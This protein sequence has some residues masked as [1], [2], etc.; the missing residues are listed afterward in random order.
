MNRDLL[1]QY[2]ESLSD[3]DGRYTRLQCVNYRPGHTTKRGVFS[4]VF[5]AH[6]L[7]RDLP[8]ALKF[9]DPEHIGNAYRMLGF[10]REP[11]ILQPLIGKRRCLQLVMPLET[12]IWRHDPAVP[13]QIGRASCRA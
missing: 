8:V 12:H 5:K 3:L 6:D 2:L 11:M 7:T 4:L 1:V 13:V 10:E 9:F